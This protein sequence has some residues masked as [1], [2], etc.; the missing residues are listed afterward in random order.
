MLSSFWQGITLNRF[1][2]HQWREVSLLHQFLGFA[3]AWRRGSWLLPW[4]DVIA[5]SIIA[6]L[7]ALAPYVSTTLIG[8][9]LLACAAFWFLLTLSDEASEGLTPIHLVVIVYWGIMLLA[10]ALSPVRAAAISGLIKL[11]LN[12][13]LFLLMARVLRRPRLRTS[14]VTVYLLT[15]LVV[16]VVG[17]RQWFF[18]AE[19]LATWV[20]PTSN[21][22]GTTRVYSYLGNPNLLAG[23]LIPAVMLS[24]AAVFAWPRWTPKALALLSVLIN[25]ACLVLTF[26]RGGLLG[27]VAGGFALLVLLVQFWSLRFNQFWKQWAIPVLIGGAAAFVVLAVAALE[28]LRDRVLSIFAGRSDSSNN[29]RINVW[30]AVIDMIKDRPIL[31]IGPGNDAFNRVYP[32]YQK[33]RYTAL[34]AYSVFLEIAVEA[35]F[36]GLCVFFWLLTVT[37]G[38]GWRQLQ[39]L[40][41]IQSVQAYWL[42]A[43]LATMV[44]MLVHGLVDT[45]WYRPQVSTLWWMMLALVASYYTSKPK[46]LSPE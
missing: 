19:D 14:L 6:L 44:G 37:F 33:P 32:F 7:F 34:S 10:T 40:R 11:T 3:R 21:F 35:G 28:P 30:V 43:A 46:A 31:G 29:F 22:A 8:V 38:Q 16:S 13:L 23:Y 4:G 25:M 2:L 20:D 12:V 15:S 1:A 5:L 27:F 18:G 42:I 39:R 36:I 17:L 41:E 45:I 26:S 24:G 9:L